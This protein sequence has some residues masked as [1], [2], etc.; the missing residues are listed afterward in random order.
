M[1]NRYTGLMDELTL[2]CHLEE[3]F[4]RKGFLVKKEIGTGYGIADLVLTKLS[5]KKCNIRKSNKQ[6]TPLLKESYFTVLRHLPDIDEGL[7]A[8]DY[9]ELLKK[10][11]LSNHF[12]KYDVLKTLESCG[13]VKEVEN[14]KYFK[15]N[16]WVPLAKEVIAIEAKLQNWKRGFIQAN[17]YKAFADKVY[18]AMPEQYAHRVD[19]K[20]LKSQ[21]IGL[22]ILK[23]SQKAIRKEIEPVQ[24]KHFVEDK[25]NYVL[26]HYLPHAL[27][28]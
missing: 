1:Q 3:I 14:Q 16:G 22:I 21:N 8:M 4:K 7:D 19:K 18:L 24:N 13:F 15:V 2:V 9:A 28:Y 6:I 5:K 10:T 17:R 23:N 25:R 26:E 12:L 20:L 27:S 11:N